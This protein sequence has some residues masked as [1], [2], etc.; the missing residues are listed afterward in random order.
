MVLDSDGDGIIDCKDKEP[1]S[2]P[3]YNVNS[4]GIAQVPKGPEPVTEDDVNRIVDAK[5]AAMPVADPT[6]DWFLPMIHFGLDR[7]N[8]RQ[9][10]YGKLHNVATVMKLN[11]ELRV[12]AIGYTDKLAGNCYNDVLSYNRANSAI[13]Y[14]VAKYGIARDRFILNWGGEN[15]NLVPT[16]GSNMMNRRVEFRVATT[17]SEMAKPDCGVKKAGSGSGSGYSGNKE[18]GY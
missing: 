7:H 3:G 9:S 18:A 6:A 14:I 17:E 4:D 8:I 15:D 5:I 13:E 10:E 16:N 11:P 1:H 2:P 12:A